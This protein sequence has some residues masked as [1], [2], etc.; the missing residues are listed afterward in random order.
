MAYKKYMSRMTLRTCGGPCGC[1]PLVGATYSKALS[2]AAG[3][4]LYPLEGNMSGTKR[5]PE[6]NAETTATS[7]MAEVKVIS[8]RR[9]TLP[10]TVC[11]EYNLREGSRLTLV[12]Q[13]NGWLLTTAIVSSVTLRTPGGGEFTASMP[14]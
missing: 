2:D 11:D 14:A 7:V 1:R 13:D 8:G 9:I 4:A 10:E 6:V 12:R 5:E 3:I